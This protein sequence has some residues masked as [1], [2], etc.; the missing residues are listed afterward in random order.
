MTELELMQRVLKRLERT[1]A[2]TTEDMNELDNLKDL[3]RSRIAQLTCPPCNHNCNE[4]RDCPGRK[5]A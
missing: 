4:G 2:Y 5:N 1:L 3:L